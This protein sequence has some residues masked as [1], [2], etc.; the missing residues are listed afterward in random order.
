MHKASHWKLSW[1][2]LGIVRLGARY[3]TKHSLA[4]N[5]V[6][7][8]HAFAPRREPVGTC[9]A[10]N[11]RRCGVGLV[12]RAHGGGEASGSWRVVGVGGGRGLDVDHGILPGGTGVRVSGVGFKRASFIGHA[13]ARHVAHQ[14]VAV[15]LCVCHHA[16]H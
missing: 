5:N 8:K 16:V 9:G 4:L 12:V 3:P 6:A 2:W 7:T 10:G 1:A 15:V 11:F 13:W 14:Y